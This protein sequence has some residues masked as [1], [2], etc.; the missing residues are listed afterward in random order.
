M[1][2]LRSPIQLSRKDTFQVKVS[3]NLDRVIAVFDDPNLVTNAGL[4]LPA[5]LAEKL[6]L[7]A[8][9]NEKV[10][11]TNSSA[12]CLPG[13]KA[14]TLVHSM[15]VGGDS[16]DDTDVLRS[17]A[18]QAVLG[19][20][21]MAPSTI[22]TFLRGHDFGNIAQHESVNGEALRRAWIAG[23]APDPT[24][25]L[26]V[27]IDS[28][29]CR[30]F[31]SKKQGASF[32]YTKTRGYHPLL[33]FRADTGEVLAHRLRSG[34]AHTARGIR[35]F[36]EGLG[37]RLRHAG[38]TGKI[39]LRCDSGFWSKSVIEYCE[40][41]GWEYSITI[42]QTGPTKRLI[43]AIDPDQ[44]GQGWQPLPGY[45]LSGICQIGEYKPDQPDNPNLPARR[46]IIRRVCLIDQNNKPLFPTWDH[47]AFIT[48]RVGD[49]YA[50]DEHHRAHAVC[51][52]NIRD[53]KDNGL[54][55]C[56][57]GKFCANT[58]WLSLAVLAH[59]LTRWTLNIGSNEP[60]LATGATTRRTLITTPGRI[61]T[62]GRKQ[63]LHLPTKWPWAHTFTKILD[64][65]RTVVITT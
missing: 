39:V 56:P 6:G 4:I 1:G 36:L 13:R 64:T 35:H 15:I 46:V 29:I 51:E 42:K 34:A 9:F 37:G 62:S 8:L 11:L 63:T 57:S 22:G 28:T 26:I 45:P 12:G 61:A 43:A 25:P 60:G 50:E 21:V 18:S 7:E 24:M 27:D 5:T 20:V 30:V 14:L 33:A 31:G 65:L 2:V 40:R 23:A 54:K 44:T 16:I 38:W 47:H 48:N 49:I 41:N 58:A 32:G 52:L 19:H 53:L 17:G 3:R 59:N 10:H 55:H